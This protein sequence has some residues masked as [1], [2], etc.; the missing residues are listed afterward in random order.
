MRQPIAVRQSGFTITEVVV[1]LAVFSIGIVM[2]SSLIGSVQQLQQNARY[3]DLATQAARAEIEYIRN[4][5][6]TT[7]TNG[8]SFTSS[9]PPTLPS[10]STGTVAVSVPAN[11][12]SSKQVDVTVKFPVGSL[13]KQVTISAYVDAPGS[14]S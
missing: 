14:T 7:I 6:Y 13:T 2:L 11:A 3:L 5:Q 9:L 12:P 1:V 4:S 8:T 10:G